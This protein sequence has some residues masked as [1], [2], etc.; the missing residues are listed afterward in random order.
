VDRF[1]DVH[2][3]MSAPSAPALVSHMH[4]GALGSS[5]LQAIALT[6]L[7]LDRNYASPLTTLK[8]RR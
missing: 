4:G 7:H 5:Y 1:L 6:D 8:L 2:R 3:R